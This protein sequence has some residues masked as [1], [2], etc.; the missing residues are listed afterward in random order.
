MIKKYEKDDIDQVIL[1]W[2]SAA[3]K[4]HSF[5]KIDF[6]EHEERLLREQC[7]NIAES[8][9][10]IDNNEIQGFISLFDC[11][12]V[13]LFIHP[14][15]QRQTIGRQLIDYIKKIKKDLK[16]EVFD[17]NKDAISFYEKNGFIFEKSTIHIET[18]EKL[19]I[20]KHQSNENY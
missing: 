6:F 13:G 8:W 10:F 1:I 14:L 12:I 20:L 9:V 16:V 15:Y 18:G 11:V 2:K 4:A 19:L 17:K 5:L 7:M 3:I